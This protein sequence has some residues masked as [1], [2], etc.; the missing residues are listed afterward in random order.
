MHADP[1]LSPQVAAL[2]DNAA[3]FTTACSMQDPNCGSILPFVFA[4]FVALSRCHLDKS[5]HE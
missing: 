2:L 3:C 5:A 1:T 4:P